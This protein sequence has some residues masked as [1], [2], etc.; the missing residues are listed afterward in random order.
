MIK[1]SQA[2]STQCGWFSSLVSKADNVKPVLKLLRKQG[3][4]DIREIEM[5]QGN[6]VTRVIAWTF[7]EQ[8]D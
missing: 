6:K 3:A 8:V 7:L 2:F 5:N 1:E 4:T